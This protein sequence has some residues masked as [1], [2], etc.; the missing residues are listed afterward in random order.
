MTDDKGGR[1]KDRLSLKAC[2]SCR[3]RKVRCLQDMSTSSTSCRSC[4]DAQRPCIFTE[5]SR[6]RPRERTDTRV[7]ELEN[8]VRTLSNALKQ[9]KSGHVPTVHKDRRIM[10][11]HEDGDRPV[12]EINTEPPIALL[13]TSF[14]RT[15]CL[16]RR[17]SRSHNFVSAEQHRTPKFSSAGLRVSATQS[18]TSAFS[19]GDQKVATLDVVDRGVL[20]MEEASHLFAEYVDNLVPHFPA[21]VLPPGLTACHA[22]NTKPILFLAVITAAAASSNSALNL[23]LNK[24][25]RQLYAE[26]VLVHGEQSLELIQSILITAIWYCPPDHFDQVVFYQYIHI[27]ATM[28]LDIGLDK[29]PLPS[30]S[31]I[32]SPPAALGHDP[33]SRPDS[34]TIESRRTLL[35]CYLTC[36]GVSMTLRRPNILPFSSWM[37]ECVSFL[38]TSPDAL[39]TDVRLTSWVRLRRIMEECSTSFALDDP[40]ATVSLDDTRIQLMLKGFEKVLR[41]WKDT[42][43]IGVMNETLLIDFHVQNIILHEIAMHL[44]HDVE[45][46]QPPYLIRA[47]TQ[48]E[49]RRELP[50]AYVN[51]ITVCL[52]STYDLLDT[53][54]C[55]DI[56]T[57]RVVPII[58]FV[59]MAYAT[60]I[61]IKLSLSASDPSSRVGQVLD[62]TSL[63]V[64]QYLDDLIERLKSVIACNQNRV[65]IKFLVIV[66]KLKDWYGQQKGR[67]CSSTKDKTSI[68]PLIHLAP[69]LS[70]LVL[71]RQCT[72]DDI[73]SNQLPNGGAQGLE[74]TV[75]SNDACILNSSKPEYKG[76]RMLSKRGVRDQPSDTDSGLTS[77][78][79]SL[80]D[81][82]L[83]PYTTASNFNPMLCDFSDPT[84]WAFPLEI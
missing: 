50:P 19:L 18:N 7:S 30:S 60:T 16:S 25:F 8:E 51:P 80:I 64:A 47:T 84:S 28:A 5:S 77:S 48:S 73:L 56:G 67:V 44:D 22:R 1:S 11:D 68:E 40:S 29:E 33:L 38:E 17:R 39:P 13:S 49:I 66:A 72:S 53:F 83:E 36:A 42:L 35:S 12:A 26:R 52:S 62:P 32:S 43:P 27:A 78:A 69:H 37:A 81:A 55:T 61:L 76:P 54:L 45:S 10:D 57:L 3:I 70:E 34:E 6:K 15:D 14:Q 31:S 4:V 41:I 75:E 59:R 63:R 79:S 21:V 2:E 58:N 71:E 23:I 74:S 65:A 9:G 24:E 46:F 82:Y 20:S